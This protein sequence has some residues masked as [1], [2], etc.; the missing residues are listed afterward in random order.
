MRE[1]E[2]G[3]TDTADPDTAHP[4]TAHPDTAHPDTAHP[5][6]AHPDTAHPDTAHPDTAH[7]DTADTRQQPD[8]PASSVPGELPNLITTV[9]TTEA[10]VPDVAMTNS[11]HRMLEGRG[12]LPGQHYLDSGYPLRRADDPITHRVRRRADHTPAGLTTHRKPGPAPGST[13]PASP[14]TSTTNSPPAPKD[15]PAP[16]GT[17]CANAAPTPS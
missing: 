10:T 2:A 1:R 17:R 11:I 8:A 16:H 7:P 9:A 3:V 4:D 15:T 13:A 5:D 12:L 6:T 14:S